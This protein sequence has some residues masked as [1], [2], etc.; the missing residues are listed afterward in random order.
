[1]KIKGSKLQCF[2]FMLKSLSGITKLYEIETEML[3]F[4][5][6]HSKMTLDTLETLDTWLF[7]CF[8]LKIIL[9]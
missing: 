8:L 5:T 6:L 2:G 9:P 7:F 4:T 1:M 3:K